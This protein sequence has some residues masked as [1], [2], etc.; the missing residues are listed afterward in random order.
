MYFV[1]ALVTLQRCILIKE[2]LSLKQLLDGIKITFK[3]TI[4]SGS[5]KAERKLWGKLKFP[6]SALNFVEPHSVVNVLPVQVYPSGNIKVYAFIDGQSNRTLAI[7]QLFDFFDIL[8]ESES[9]TLLSCSG[10]STCSGRRVNRL[11]VE[12]LD[13]SYRFD[14]PTVIKCNE[15]LDNKDEIPTPEVAFYRT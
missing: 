9:H 6:T 5:L 13:G 14:L 7:S 8:S 1:E 2:I 10:Q 3:E 11:E 4:T 12:A 15:I